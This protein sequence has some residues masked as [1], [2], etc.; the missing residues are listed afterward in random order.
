MKKDTERI[1]DFCKDAVLKEIEHCEGSNTLQLQ[2]EYGRLSSYSNDEIETA[3]NFLYE[4]GTI[5]KKIDKN[6]AEDDYFRFGWHL[7]L[8]FWERV[9]MYMS[10]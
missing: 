7:N 4:E 10:R 2:L 9:K 1:D 5:Y 8:T 3:L 6:S